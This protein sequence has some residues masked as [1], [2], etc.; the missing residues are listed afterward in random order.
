[1]LRFQS[2]K[3]AIDVTAKHII[4]YRKKILK[5]CVPGTKVKAVAYFLQHIPLLQSKSQE[6]RFFLDLNEIS[7]QTNRS[8]HFNSIILKG[9]GTPK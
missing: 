7:Y 6:F 2:V 5:T 8:N 1:M 3:K 4:L 9:K